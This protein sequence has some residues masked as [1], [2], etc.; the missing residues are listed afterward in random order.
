M[1]P[2]PS[3]TKLEVFFNNLGGTQI[4]I[5]E[6]EDRYLDPLSLAEQ[7]SN[8]LHR[9]L[10]LFLRYHKDSNKNTLKRSNQLFDKF[11]L[12]NEKIRIYLDHKL[13]LDDRINEINLSRYL[14]NFLPRELPLMLSSSSP[15]RDFLTYSGSQPFTRKC[16]R[17]RGASGIDGNISIAVGISIALG[18]LV[19]V[20]GDLAFLHDSNAFL[21]SQ[22]KGHPLL[23]I[24]IDNQGGGI[25][26]QIELDKFYIGN[27]DSLFSMP[28][29]SSPADIANSHNIPC[30][31]ILS[32]DDLKRGIAWAMHLSGPVLLHIR[33]NA[34]EDS[35]LRKQIVNDLKRIID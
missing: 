8:G 29:T 4:L 26:K 32:F 15:I 24:L 9:W 27:V 18:P 30:R 19:L 31:K 22:P 20:C 3:S 12:M 33:T 2:L 7:Y 14:L 16:S 11:N 35:L 6:G 21:L 17:F 28:Q 1:G 25:F 10:L 34:T 5:T 13:N 23:I